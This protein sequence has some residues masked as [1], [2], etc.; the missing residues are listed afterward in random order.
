[1]YKPCVYKLSSKWK[2]FIFI[3]FIGLIQRC[4]NVFLFFFLER[5]FFLFFEKSAE[6]NVD[7]MCIISVKSRGALPPNKID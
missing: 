4:E 7:L 3:F 5:V 2:S 1:M 6:K